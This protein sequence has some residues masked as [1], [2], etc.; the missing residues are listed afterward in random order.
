M[1]KHYC[2]LLLAVVS[3]NVLTAQD[4]VANSKWPAQTPAI[5]GMTND[6]AKPF[7]LYDGS[8]GVL[9]AITNDSVN[10]YVCI[11]ASDEAKAG[12]MMRTGWQLSLTG[13]EKNKKVSADLNFPIMHAAPEDNQPKGYS[14]GR[15]RNFAALVNTYHLQFNTVQA[16]G[17]KT[18][19]GVVNVTGTSG[20]KIQLGVDS[21][22]G[23]VYEIAI[24]LA[25]LFDAKLIQLNEQLLLTVAVNGTQIQSTQGQNAGSGWGNTGTDMTQGSTTAMN[26]VDGMNGMNRNTQDFAPAN[27]DTNNNGNVRTVSDK[28]TLKQKF[29]LAAK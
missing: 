12:K 13:K 29:K 5:D 9:F 16:K 4:D 11:T 10:L 28:T 25:E 27:D 26:R 24:P 17:F 22:Q 8:T 1:L 14:N 20:I 21:I 6:W 18:Q 19:N 2:I 15:S 23:L 3:A 7:N